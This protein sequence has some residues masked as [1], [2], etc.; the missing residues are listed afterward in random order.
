MQLSVIVNNKYIPVTF[1]L[2]MFFF[3]LL[4]PSAIISPT[5]LCVNL[6]QSALVEHILF[7]N[8]P[9]TALCSPH[10][11]Q[12]TNS[13]FKQYISNENSL[14]STVLIWVYCRWLCACACCI[15]V[16]PHTV[17]ASVALTKTWLISKMWNALLKGKTS[18]HSDHALTYTRTHKP[19]T[20]P[21]NVLVASDTEMMSWKLIFLF[22][23]HRRMVSEWKLVWWTHTSWYEQQKCNY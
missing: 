3:T 18:Y 7:S 21:V 11:D 6:A 14:L 17:A 16:K 19:C 22:H 1:C 12:F 23:L 8:Y 15:H 9:P 20:S 5:C 4:V 2:C 13:V 10:H